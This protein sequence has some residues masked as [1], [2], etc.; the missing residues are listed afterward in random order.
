MKRG[1]HR[2]DGGALARSGAMSIRGLP[3]IHSSASGSS[4]R[5]ASSSTSRPLYGRSRPKNRTTGLPTCARSAGNGARLLDAGE[6]LEGA[7]RDHVDLARIDAER[8]DEPLPAVLGVHDDG[9]DALVQ[10]ALRGELPAARLARQ[11]VMGRQHERL[12]ARQQVDVER[13]DRQP[14]KVHDV[15]GRGGAPVAQHVRDVLG[16]LRGEAPSRPGLATAAAVEALD[17]RRSP[18]GRARRRTRSGSSAGGRRRPRAPA[19]P[20]ARGRRAA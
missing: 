15:R 10:P 12:G 20:T 11:D 16:E 13:L 5:H 8:F 14:L 2:T 17:A 4:L 1:T 19:P 9:V 6:V 7:V 3:T 18:A